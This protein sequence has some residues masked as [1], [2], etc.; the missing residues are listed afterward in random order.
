M[1]DELT[2][3][4]LGVDSTPV[5]KAVVDLD[6]LTASGDKAEVSTAKLGRTTDSFT[7]LRNEQYQ[8]ELKLREQLDASSVS[9]DRLTAGQALFLEKLQ[10]MADTTNLT[11]KAL[12]EYEA[13]EMGVT[14]GAQAYIDKITAVTEAQKGH[15]ISLDSN[16]AKIEALRIAHDAAIGSYSRMGSAM[17]VFGNASGASAAL[18]SLA[19]L[20]YALAAAALGVLA[21][22]YHQ[23]AA[24][25][26]A[27][28][29]S[30]ITT[31]GAVGVTTQ[32]L[33]AMASGMAASTGATIGKSAEAINAFA[34]S[35]RFGADEVGK[36]AAT[37]IGLQKQLGISLEDSVKQ[38]NELGKSPVDA[39]IKLNESTH[40][41]T[42]SVYEHI[43]ALSDLGDRTGAAKAAEEAYADAMDKRIPKLTEN[44]GY[45]ER[46]WNAVAG[47]AKW[48]WDEMLGIGRTED[49]VAKVARQIAELE[50]HAAPGRGVFSGLSAGD[51]DRLAALKESQIV[52]NALAK[53]EQA[54]A[55][56][57]K[58][59]NDIVEAGVIFAGI[60]DK[61][62]DRSAV[63]NRLITQATIEGLAAHKTQAEI[64]A[65]TQKIRDAN[66]AKAPRAARV[67]G[68]SGYE[69]LIS[70]LEKYAALTEIEANTSAKVSANDKWRVD[71]L[72]ML[73]T[74]YGKGATSL[75]NYLRFLDAINKAHNDRD[76]ADAGLKQAKEEADAYKEYDKSVESVNKLTGSVLKQIDAEKL[77]LASIGL[78]KGAIEMLNVKKIEQQALD[79]KRR[80]DMLAGLGDED[81]MRNGL[82]AEAAA[83]AELARL[84]KL[85]ADETNKKEQDGA[86]AYW[87]TIQDQAIATQTVVS[88]AFKGMEDALVTFATTGKLDFNGLAN[89]IIADLIRIQIQQ[90]ITKPLAQAM[91]NAGG[92]SGIASGVASLFGF[93]TGGNP[94]PGVPYLV[95]ENG[96]EIRVDTGPGVITPNHLSGSGGAASMTINQPIVINAQNA[97]AE[98]IGQIRAM[99]PGLLAT[100]SR[101]ITAVVQQAFAKQGMKVSI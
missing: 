84:K 99:M 72:A 58:K 90:S 95:G 71:A 46:G 47:G 85:Q 53:Q 1:S 60:N 40:Y 19:A 34:A 32:Q 63:A 56:E 4:V 74:A 23:G 27:F 100:N 45:I 3:L 49:P 22:A 78:S 52:I 65:T 44:L 101:V 25:S 5:A 21:V 70:D 61:Y 37:A 73:D 80:A 51:A 20:P 14:K 31:G 64:D 67:P 36:F 66:A 24:E 11:K 13:A 69:K 81:L 9:T 93:A 54:I 48:A 55:A 86:Y 38:F 87:S 50:Q 75:G 41:L 10:R 16:I 17:L 94:T 76:A 2:N 28:T 18:F 96:P 88:K 79:A 92:M 7:K 30:L 6:K 91:S 82:L 77:Q 8:A 12:L 15:G 29:K 83:Y 97:S 39:T 98:T 59:Q 42:L 62:L 26:E 57:K 33:S 68:V 43:K 89:S 35:G